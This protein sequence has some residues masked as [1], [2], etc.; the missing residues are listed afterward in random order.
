M[1]QRYKTV[2]RLPPLSFAAWA[3][4]A[5]VLLTAGGAMAEPV[6]EPSHP[7]VKLS[8]VRAGRLLIRDGQLERA[9]ALL[10]QARPSGEKE[11]IERLR[12]LGEVEMRLGMPEHAA[13]RFEAILAIRPGLVRIRLELLRAYRLSRS[14]PKPDDAHKRGGS[15]S[16]DK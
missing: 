14:D 11:Q 3:A 4:V 16:V 15:T 7:P 2:G 9:Q 8:D 13:Q 12:L 1:I 6:P 5:M 10:E